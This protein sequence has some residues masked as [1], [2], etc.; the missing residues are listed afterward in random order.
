MRTRRSISASLAAL[1]VCSLGLTACGASDSAAPA[2]ST[3]ASASAS[4]SAA[5]FEP[6]AAPATP[7]GQTPPTSRPEGVPASGWY[8]HYLAW[9]NRVDVWNDG[10]LVRSIPVAGNP[11]IKPLPEHCPLDDKFVVARSFDDQYDLK[12][13]TRFCDGRGVGMHAIP[14]NPTTG[15]PEMD[16]A[17]LGKAPGNGAPLSHGCP[18]ATEADAKWFQQ[19]VPAGTT[20][21]ND[22]R[23]PV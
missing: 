6:V 14:T 2:P 9:V 18:R 12:Y 22:Y 20:I 1:A 3:S 8:V 15:L 19:T 23:K 10:A 7:L 5:A 21:W 13:F 11:T 17:D 16:A 4:S